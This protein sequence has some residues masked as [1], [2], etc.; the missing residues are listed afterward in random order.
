MGHKTG[1][2][3]ESAKNLIKLVKKCYRP[4]FVNEKSDGN[5]F[6]LLS[7]F[8]VPT[9]SM[10]LFLWETWAFYNCCIKNLFTPPA[11]KRRLRWWKTVG[12]VVFCSSTIAYT[13]GCNAVYFTHVRHSPGT[14]RWKHVV[15]RW[16]PEHRKFTLARR[17][18]AVR[19]KLWTKWLII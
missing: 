15:R 6:K 2:A 4:F 17:A 8:S 10:P 13:V 16:S 1:I 3:S 12:K 11:R 5:I 18:L 7:L 14:I 19:H 9:E